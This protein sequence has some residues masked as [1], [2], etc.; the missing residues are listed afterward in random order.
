M[1]QHQNFTVELF[2]MVLVAAFLTV[3]GLTLL[4]PMS[5]RLAALASQS[6]AS[7]STCGGASSSNVAPACLL[8]R[9]SSAHR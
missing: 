7:D 6:I 1:D 2:G 8:F 9:L 4:E 5:K 3:V